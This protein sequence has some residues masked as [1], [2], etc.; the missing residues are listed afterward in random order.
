MFKVFIDSIIVSSQDPAKLSLTVRGL[1]VQAL[2]VIMLVLQAFGIGAIEADIAA[3][4][5]GVTNLIAIVLTFIGVAM[6][7]WGIVRKLGTVSDEEFAD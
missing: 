2:P 7:T 6:S 4:I 1:L 3:I 5:E